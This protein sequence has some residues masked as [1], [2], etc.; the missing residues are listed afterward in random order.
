MRLVDLTTNPWQLMLPGEKET[1]L[2]K[3]VYLPGTLD[4]FGVGHEDRLDNSCH[5]DETTAQSFDDDVIATRF[6]RKH[7]Y[8][9]PA[10]FEQEITIAPADKC[11]TFFEIERAR[12]VRVYLD[13][14]EISSY[15]EQTIS[16]PHVFELTGHEGIHRLRVESDNSYPGLPHDAIHRR[17]QMRHRQIGMDFLVIFVFVRKIRSFYRRYACTLRVEESFAQK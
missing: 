1:S 5:P 14:E 15:E 10:Y 13:G 3:M 8:E 2:N 16:T 6:T 9:G 4:E 17:Q 12:C 7:T 11:R